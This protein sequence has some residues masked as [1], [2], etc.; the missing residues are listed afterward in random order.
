MA[1]FSVLTSAATGIGHT[2]YRHRMSTQPQRLAADRALAAQARDID[3]ASVGD[4]RVAQFLGVEFRMSETAIVAERK[5]LGA[6]W[7][8]LTIAHTLA[9][10]D[11]RGMTTAQVLHLHD[12]GMGW[13]EVAAGL[14]FKLDE[15]VQ[16][17]DAESRVARGRE[18]ADGRMAPIRG[19]GF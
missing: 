17:V 1:L 4:T 19:D 18:R 8:N 11:V 13:G 6:S 15:A 9:A 5:D 3:R 7:G 16:A 10:S 14:R 2:G 12:R